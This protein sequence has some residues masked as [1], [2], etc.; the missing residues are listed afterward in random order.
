MVTARNQSSELD[1]N[2]INRY[3]VCYERLRP[4]S[5]A[6][7]EFRATYLHY[8]S[9]WRDTLSQESYLA[10]VLLGV[11]PGS[12]FCGGMTRYL[13][14][15]GSRLQ[16]PVGFIHIPPDCE[17]VHNDNVLLPPKV[18]TSLL[19][20]LVGRIV[21]GFVCL[22]NRPIQKIALWGFGEFGGIVRNPTKYFIAEIL[23]CVPTGSDPSKLLSMSHHFPRLPG[24]LTIF[25]RVFELAETVDSAR[26]GSYYPTMEPIYREAEQH[27][28][29]CG[30][31][32][33]I[34]GLGVDASQCQRIFE[35][36]TF[37]IEIQ[38]RGFA[39]TATSS[40][41]IYYNEVPAINLDLIAALNAERLKRT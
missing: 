9:P 28:D 8:N 23:G 38:S 17:A 32:D 14:E 37:L 25:P 41:D 18:L 31:L 12:F 11:D 29:L 5:K 36:P 4:F 34:I 19:S 3:L 33:L 16:I 13:F 24:A 26:K 30:G 10:D 35:R 1:H 40:G 2:E 27:L 20:E 15:L 22:G 39:S 6:T 7:A 21:S